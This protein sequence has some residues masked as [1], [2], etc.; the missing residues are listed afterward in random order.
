MGAARVPAEHDP[1]IERLA[2]NGDDVVAIVRGDH[3]LT[4]RPGR[5]DQRAEQLRLKLAPHLVLGCVLLG[6][7]L[8]P[9]HQEPGILGAD[10]E[11]GLVPALKRLPD[12]QRT[13]VWLVHAC[14]WSH[15]EAAEAM[16]ISP[17]TVATHVTRALVA[18]RQRLEVA[19]DA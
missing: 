13:A 11:P 12:Q 9:H 4:D 10:V 16:G 18:L 15:G 19:T 7:V 1:S 5:P 14:D 8:G 2:A 3:Q 17:S 6:Q